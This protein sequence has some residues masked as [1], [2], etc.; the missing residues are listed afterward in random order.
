MNLSIEEKLESARQRIRDCAALLPEEINTL[1]TEHLNARFVESLD[2]FSYLRNF[3]KASGMHLW[4]E[5]GNRYTDMLAC[6]GSAPLGHNHPEV[7]A[8]IVEALDS[9][10][11]HFILVA[12]EPLPSALAKR[13][14]EMMP[15]ELS[16]S[17]FSSSG[18]EA[19]DGALKLARA[20]TKRHRFVYADNA[21]HGTTFGALSVTG[22]K[23]HRE[24]FEPLLPG[25]TAVPWGDVSAVEKQLAKRDVAAVILEPVQAEGGIHLP[26]PRYLAR[27]SELCKRYGT[28]LIADEVQT[29]LGR[30]G[31]MFACE[32]EG[33]FPM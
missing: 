16:V 1:T 33:S 10:L 13:L 2:L 32:Q 20:A 17:F 3:R 15:G 23:A 25:S 8:G 31:A 5:K 19:V 7:R 14:A 6:Y 9:E 24:C 30:L 26:P 28:L 12:P 29:G 27:V 21:Y 4:D 11:P 18:S 22:D